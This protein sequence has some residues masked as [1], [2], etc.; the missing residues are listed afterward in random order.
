MGLRDFILSKLKPT[1]DLGEIRPRTQESGN[2]YGARDHL[3]SYYQDNTTALDKRSQIYKDMDQLDNDIIST[4]LDMGSE[5]ATQIDIATG[6]SLWC[7]SENPKYKDI[8][9]KLFSRIKI[10]EKLKRWA[11]EVYKYGDFFLKVMPG[12]GRIKS[13]DDT[14]FPYQIC[15]IESYGTLVGF[16]DLESF[17]TSPYFEGASLLPPYSIVH[18]RTPSS[19]V[20]EDLLPNEVYQKYEIDRNPLYG[21]ATFIKSRK[22]EKRIGLINDA[23]AMTRLA[24]STLYRIHSVN[25][26]DM[27]NVPQRKK[28]MTDYENMI[29]KSPGINLDQ[30]KADV[31]TKGLSLF[32]EIFSPKD[33]EGK[34]GAEINDIGG[35]ADVTGI[36]DIDLLMSQRF[37]ILGVPKSYLSFDEAQSF[38][39]LMA[40]DTRYARK[41][42]ALQKAMISGITALCQI[43]LALHDLD[44]DT[45]NFTI[46]LVP[47]STNG[48]LDRNDALNAVID[49]CNNIKTFFDADNI[50]KD[51]LVQ[52]LV[53]NYLKFPNFDMEQIFKK[54]ES[55]DEVPPAED[56]P[57]AEEVPD[58]SIE[59]KI[60]YLLNHN[61]KMRETLQ[62]IE[63][64]KRGI[65]PSAL[66]IYDK[67]HLG[68]KEK[69]LYYD[70]TNISKLKK[71]NDE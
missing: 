59:R 50:N 11:R 7:A 9:D 70:R 60:E 52:Y 14:L 57:P 39:N 64:K 53:T 51:Y 61:P 17:K 22:I 62:N 2:Y 55:T 21:S 34:G 46:H 36:A 27:T 4:V 54:E 71:Q 8:I 12:E 15:R 43:E 1:S 40:L 32:R 20:I 56:V 37:G 24:R 25:V 47:V 41:I 42:V 38:N 30:N 69:K 48:E 63:R 68:L 16:L 66:D 28:I 35:T 19:R 5:D 26:G 65:T 23:L 6:K 44:P 18:F 58:E 10:E 3:S 67:E 45:S 13:V 33:N 29:R 31:D 49:I